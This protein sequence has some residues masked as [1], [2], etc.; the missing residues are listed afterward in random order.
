MVKQKQL[1]LAGPILRRIFYEAKIPNFEEHAADDSSPVQQEAAMLQRRI[2]D[3]RKDI[4][5]QKTVE[6]RRSSSVW[7]F[8]N[9]FTKKL[10]GGDLNE[11][12][13]ENYNKR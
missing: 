13:N 5:R 12:E 11:N 9:M 3:S 2:K 1:L 4:R 7:A 10:H 8:V 6:N